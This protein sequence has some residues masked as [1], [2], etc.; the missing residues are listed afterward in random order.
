[1]SASKLIYV[2]VETT[3]LDPVRHGI[4][5]LSG[6]IEIDGEVVEHFDHRVGLFADD[7]IDADA[8]AVSGITTAQLAEYHQACEVYSH[9]IALLEQ[10]VDRFDKRDKFHFLAYNAPFDAHFLRQ[11]FV[12]NGDVYF[13]SWFWHPPI[14][15]MGLAAMHLIDRR[16]ELPNF[17]LAT[18]AGALGIEVENGRLHDSLYDIH[19]TR[20]MFQRIAAKGACGAA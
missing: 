1:M 3:G 10:Y 17:K 11:W 7:K 14:D 8:I 6:A 15:V 12:K 2:D 19:L 18:V 16:H 20:Q 5:Q 4:H 13:G 9:F